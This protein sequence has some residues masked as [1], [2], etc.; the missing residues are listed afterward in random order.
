MKFQQKYFFEDY[1]GKE[2]SYLK[3]IAENPELAKDGSKQWDFECV[4]GKVITTTPYRVVSGHIKSCGCMRYKNIVHKEHRRDNLQKVNPEDYIG[5]ERN[6]LKVIGFIRPKEKGRTKL[7][8]Q[9]KCG[10]IVYVL[11][12]Q[13]MNGAVKSCGCQRMDELHSRKT[14]GMSK[15][16][17]YV[18]WS[19]MIGR[20]YNTNNSNYERYGGRGI[21]VCDE[22][23]DSP[24]NFIKWAEET[25]GRQPG[26]TLDRSDNDGP[27]APWNCR[28][29]T[30]HEQSRNK[31]S[32]IL[33]TFNGK[34]QCLADWAKET[35][36]QHETLRGRYKS[37]W[38]VEDILTT[39]IG[40]KNKAWF[41]P[42]E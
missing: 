28:W 23:K 11:P 6:R 4:C 25:G 20:C 18:E 31:R 37:G 41:K 13:F 17:M 26:T 10:K 7:E 15:H 12:Y 29:V 27:Y 39:P 42:K 14:H 33:L 8:C 9:C 2:L 1:R 36:I 32:N 38:S 34:T 24:E 5:M 40:A 35:G 21:Y 22:W 16:P 19:S 30:M 3:P